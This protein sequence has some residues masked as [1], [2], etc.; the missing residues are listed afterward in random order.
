MTITQMQ[1]KFI[2]CNEAGRNFNRVAINREFVDELV[3]LYNDNLDKP[4]E[5]AFK[6]A[7]TQVNNRFKALYGDRYESEWRS[8]YA[9]VII[10]IKIAFGLTVPIVSTNAIVN[11]YKQNLSDEEKRAIIACGVCKK[12]LTIERFN[13]HMNILMF[14]NDQATSNYG[15]YTAAQRLAAYKKIV[16]RALIREGTIS[17]Q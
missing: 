1:Q 2:K 7:V 4:S 17:V 14:N 5:E 12:T 8:F 15:M 9:S 11:S 10:P 3:N 16:E 6:D 13:T